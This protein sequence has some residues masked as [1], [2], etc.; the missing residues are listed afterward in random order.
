MKKIILASDSPRRKSLLDM[1]GLDFIC[2]SPKTEEHFDLNQNPILE[3]K[4]IARE[5]ANSIAGIIEDGLII[6]ADTIVL[7]GGK[8]YGKPVNEADAFE[9]LAN[10]RGRR[11]EVLTAICIKDIGTQNIDVAVEITRVFF[12]NIDDE[13]IH[14]YIATGEP[15][16]KAGAYGIQGLGSVFVSRI[17]GCYYNVVGLPIMKLYS[18]LGKYGT[19]ILGNRGLGSS[20]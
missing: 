11:H 4:R 6:A 19:N 15:M 20:E 1:I 7:C 17:E 16:D 13:E 14:N 2:I 9:K 18:M 8:V 10:L 3:I 12:R 5:K